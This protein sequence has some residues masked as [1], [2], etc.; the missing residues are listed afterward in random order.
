[1]IIFTRLFNFWCLKGQLDHIDKFRLFNILSFIGMIADGIIIYSSITTIITL[2]PSNGLFLVFLDTTIVSFINIVLA[3]TVS[4][5]D[6]DFFEE[7][8]DG[9]KINKK[10]NLDDE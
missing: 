7:E 2:T 6:Y 4:K 9:I 8:V 5:K 10:F 1:M 3:L